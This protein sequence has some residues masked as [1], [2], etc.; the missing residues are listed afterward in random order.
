[1]SG[2]YQVC[3]ERFE[4]TGSTREDSAII[5]SILKSLLSVKDCRTGWCRTGWCRSGW[6]RT[7]WCRAKWCRTRWCRIGW[8]RTGWCRSGWCITRWCR[9]RWYR[10]RWCRTGFSRTRWRLHPPGST[11]VSSCS[12]WFV[13]LTCCRNQ[14]TCF[15]S[16]SLSSV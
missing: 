2:T 1:M 9:T 12:F 8:C 7:R 15:H 11:Q 14:K 6:C 13:S 3:A 5:Q 16:V 10:T 4:C